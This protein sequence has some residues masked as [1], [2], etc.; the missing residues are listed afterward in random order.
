MKIFSSF[1]HFLIGQFQFSF[2]GGLFN[3]SSNTTSQYDQ[4]TIGGTAPTVG[5]Q[6]VMINPTGGSV[7]LVGNTGPLTTGTTNRFE[8]PNTEFSGEETGGGLL[9]GNYTPPSFSMDYGTGNIVTNDPTVA[10]AAIV[11]TNN[12][13]NLMAETANLGIQ[14]GTLLAAMGIESGAINTVAA[15]Q[16]VQ[17]AMTN[18]KLFGESM[19]D[20]V[21]TL[22]DSVL[23]TVA[24][25]TEKVTGTVA[26][27]ADPESAA[28]RS[29]M[30]VAALAVVAVLIVGGIYAYKSGK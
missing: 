27:V 10:I 15:L 29:R 25:L 16:T 4:S 28:N 18:V 19:V 24:G 7:V 21:G 20:S 22:T 23:D 30:N 14:S 9:T 11:N 26:D 6:G 3:R 17:T 2:I 5:S 13:A 12:V 8:R 1:S